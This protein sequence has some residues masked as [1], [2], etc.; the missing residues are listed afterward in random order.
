MVSQATQFA[1]LA[2][3]LFVLFCE[4]VTGFNPVNLEEEIYQAST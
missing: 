4:A 1:F 3:F 2:A